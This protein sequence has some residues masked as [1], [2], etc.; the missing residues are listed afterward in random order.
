MTITNETKS[1]DVEWDEKEL[2]IG[3]KIPLSYTRSKYTT[4]MFLNRVFINKT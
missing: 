2:K 1:Y 3:L 4:M